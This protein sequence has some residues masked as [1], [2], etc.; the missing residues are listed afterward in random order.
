MHGIF[1]GVLLLLILI[2]GCK[3]NTTT[4]NPVR[5]HPIADNSKTSLDW[6][7]TYTGTISCLDCEG[8]VMT[9]N[10]QNDGT[11]ELTT[12]HNGKKASPIFQAGTFS[13]DDTG[14]KI[15]LATENE[16]VQFQVGENV[17]FPLDKE[18][19]RLAENYSEKNLLIQQ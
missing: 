12:L 16:S 1:I 14:N 15:I 3:E 19:K 11:F 13:W 6:G 4:D 7:G 18:G 5:N 2:T 10:I 8:M 9:L 17:L